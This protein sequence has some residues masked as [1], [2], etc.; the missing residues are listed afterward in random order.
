MANKKREP[1]PR[2]LF[3]TSPHGEQ[4]LFQ[5]EPDDEQ[6]V[7]NRLF[8][9]RDKAGNSITMTGEELLS[10]E[11]EWRMFCNMNAWEI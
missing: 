4:T 11:R 9:L 10:L 3:I 1:K 7:P 2:K 6:K 5:L 8:V